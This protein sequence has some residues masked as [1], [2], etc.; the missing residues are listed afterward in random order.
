[1]TGDSSARMR[2]MSSQARKWFNAGPRPRSSVPDAVQRSTRCSAE[3]G[4]M[5]GPRISSAPRR[6]RGAL[7]SIRGTHP[8]NSPETSIRPASGNRGT[9]NSRDIPEGLPW[10]RP[11]SPTIPS[12]AISGSR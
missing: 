3:P 6:E 1:M 11:I 2:I 4:P 5:A 7:R 9:L 10:C 12:C 8:R